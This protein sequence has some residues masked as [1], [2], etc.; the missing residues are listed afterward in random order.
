VKIVREHYSERHA[1]HQADLI[2]ARHV[3]EHIPDPVDFLARLRRVIGPRRQTALFFEVPNILPTLIDILPWDL[4]YEHCSSFSAGTLARTF[5]Q[6]GFDVVGTE[7]AYA[8]QFLSI[9]AVPSLTAHGKMP[10]S[11]RDLTE[12]GDRVSRFAAIC[13][14]RIAERKKKIQALA[15]AGKKVVIW[16]AGARGISYLNI[17][18]LE[19]EIEYIVDINPRKHG[20]YVPGTGQRIVPPTF[21][22]EYRPDLVIVMNPNYTLE[23]AGDLEKLGVACPLERP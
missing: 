22:R 21:L 1:Q 20:T 5:A 18:A 3:L 7:E 10:S 6:A 11:L 4:I 8:R 9:D 23:V 19:E 12:I 15:R 16:G 17:L 2:I 13:P 14:E